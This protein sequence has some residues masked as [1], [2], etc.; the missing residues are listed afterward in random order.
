MK[1]IIRYIKNTIR[2]SENKFRIK[3]Q[4]EA[5]RRLRAEKLTDQQRWEKKEEFYHDWNERTSML[6]SM[7]KPGSKVIEFGAGSAF[8]RNELPEDVIYTP[9]DILKRDKDFLICDL[10]KEIEFELFQFDTVIFSGVLEYVYEIDKV[11]S[12]FPDNIKT[13]IMSYACSDICKVDRL[14]NGWLSDYNS[15]ELEGIFSS[16]GFYIEKSY[17]WRHQSIYYVVRE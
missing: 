1:K 8:L 4:V 5:T 7:V 6:G 11:F 2:H 16:Y 12:Q 14:E 10:N 15:N 13:V 3:K 9:S 17:E